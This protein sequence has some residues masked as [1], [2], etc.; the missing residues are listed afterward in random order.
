[1]GSAFGPVLAQ[2]SVQTVAMMLPMLTNSR[3]SFM[4][5]L[6]HLHTSFR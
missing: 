1:M 4:A 6:S 2:L 3:C 5:A